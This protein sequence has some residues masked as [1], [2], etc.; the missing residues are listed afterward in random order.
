[1]AQALTQCLPAPVFRLPTGQGYDPP[2]PPL[3]F[4]HLHGAM[5]LY[6]NY[7]Q[8][9]F[10][11]M[12]KTR[13][14]SAVIKRC[15]PPATPCDRVIRHEAVNAEAKMK[16]TQH[17]AALDPVALLHTIR[18]SQSALAAIVSPELRP[19]PRGESLERFLTKLPRRWREE[20]GPADRE[21]GV[22]P[23]RHWRTRRARSR[24]CG[25]MCWSG[26]RR[27]GR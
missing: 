15:S 1:M 2:R 18:E 16:F 3:P 21:P 27:P 10:K 19:T 20:Q 17:R 9:S 26:G 13:N 6:V 14:G 24:A 11:L 23:P 22:K 8:P 12:R 4:A 5:R 7:F 25:A